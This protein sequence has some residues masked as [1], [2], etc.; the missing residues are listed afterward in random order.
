MNSD[1]LFKING[2]CEFAYFHI[3]NEFTEIVEF[4]DV[5]VIK[6]YNSLYNDIIISIENDIINLSDKSDNILN[7]SSNFTSKNDE[8]IELINSRITIDDT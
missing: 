4:E 1:L 7:I 3:Y 5:E 2:L 6:E 8:L